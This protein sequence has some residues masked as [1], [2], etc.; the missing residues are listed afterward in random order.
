MDAT[1]VGTTGVPLEGER[2]PYVVFF[3]TAIGATTGI[4]TF[5]GR[6]QTVP[7]V[8]FTVTPASSGV[9]RGEFAAMWANC[10][11]FCSRL[12]SS[13]PTAPVVAQELLSRDAETAG[14]FGQDANAPRRRTRIHRRARSRNTHTHATF[15]HTH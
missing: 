10:T 1:A 4:R 6:R 12:V 2:P 15:T 14:V 7:G 8:C 11:Y 3:S 13:T 9:K 5:V